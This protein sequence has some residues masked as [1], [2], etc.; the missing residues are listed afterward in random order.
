MYCNLSYF[1]FPPLSIFG[2]G[3]GGE[4]IHLIYSAINAKHLIK[5]DRKFPEYFFK[6]QQFIQ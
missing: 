4:A 5:F 6:K 1:I 3:V 2:R